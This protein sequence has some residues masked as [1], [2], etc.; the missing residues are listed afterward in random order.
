MV[1]HFTL[2]EQ[3]E[4]VPERASMLRMF[5]SLRCT[6]GA[7]N[8]SVRLHDLVHPERMRM[9]LR[10]EVCACSRRR[11][12]AAQRAPQTFEHQSVRP[13][14]IQLISHLIPCTHLV[15]DQLVCGAGRR[16]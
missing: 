14:S 4:S 8:V 2:T 10:T 13:I 12:L 11:C 3:V 9:L 6:G 7:F 1:G 15:S 5:S 16:G